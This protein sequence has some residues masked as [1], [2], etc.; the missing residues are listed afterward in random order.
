[1]EAIQLCEEHAKTIS[2]QAS[3]FHYSVP[4]KFLEDAG[5]YEAYEMAFDR[6]TEPPSSFPGRELFNDVA[7]YVEKAMVQQMFAYM[8]FHFGEPRTMTPEE[9]EEEARAAEEE[10]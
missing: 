7:G 4:R 10:A 1:M 6:V 2:I 5:A 3:K 8:V 9:L